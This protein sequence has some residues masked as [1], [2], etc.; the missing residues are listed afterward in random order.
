MARTCAIWHKIR[1]VSESPLLSLLVVSIVYV[2]QGTHLF[3]NRTHLVLQ[4]TIPIATHPLD[5]A[6][7]FNN[8][9]TTII[10]K[11]I[12]AN[13]NTPLDLTKLKDFP[14]RLKMTFYNLL[15]V[16]DENQTTGWCFTQTPENDCICVGRVTH[17]DIKS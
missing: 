12:S 6:N 4:W 16:W 13:T 9:F 5:I 17:Q 3:P 15:E 7:R 10:Q 8:L 1:I 11:Y 2:P 14:S